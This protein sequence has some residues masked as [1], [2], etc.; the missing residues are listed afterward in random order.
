MNGLSNPAMKSDCA[1]LKNQHFDWGIKPL[2]LNK[3]L[4]YGT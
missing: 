2:E 4:I 3:V 1:K